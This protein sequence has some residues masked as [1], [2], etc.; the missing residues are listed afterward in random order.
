M[1]VGDFNGD[2]KMDLAIANQGSNDVTVLLG[3]GRG[4]FTAAPGSPLNAGDA[5]VSVAVGDFN[6]DRKTDLAVV[7]QGS[8]NVTVLLGDGKGGFTVGD[9]VPT[10]SREP[11]QIAVADFNADGKADLTISHFTGRDVSVLLGN[12]K[13]GFTPAPGGPL[14]APDWWFTS[15][16]VGDLD[17]DG[18]PDIV[19]T[20]VA[21]FVQDMMQ[22]RAPR[23]DGVA[24]LLGDGKGGFAS[25]PNKSFTVQKLPRSVAVGDFNG[26]GKLDLVTANENSDNATVL[27]G[28]G[29]GRFTA[30]P[31]N[32]F[33][34]GKGPV[35]VAVG[36][37]DG[38]GKL[39]LAIANRG[40][41]SVT[42]LLGDGKGGFAEAPG[43]PFPV[44]T[45]PWSVVV[46]DFN[47]DGKP[48]LAIANQGSNNVTV[49]LNNRPGPAAPASAKPRRT[50][51]AP[52]VPIICLL[53]LLA[54]V[55]GL[56]RRLRHP[57]RRGDGV[58]LAMG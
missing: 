2:G 29:T 54:L 44:G 30:A 37:F 24:V 6:G 36:D 10:G 27:L 28:D 25:D 51:L 41:N 16:A 5:P 20:V 22:R 11:T 53:L 38:D 47:G 49:L 15:L 50:A 43:S 32:P 46:G 31:G 9:A 17:G 18:K 1:A 35:S 57:G 26:D 52:G 39:D 55:I 23:R 8:D 7:N 21:D 13:G 33:K 14:V 4:G 40:D 42:V 19:A 45:E 48:D 34:A 12:G 56:L 58:R 3:N